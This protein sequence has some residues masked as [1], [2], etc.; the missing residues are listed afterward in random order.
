[1]ICPYCEFAVD[2]ED[3]KEKSITAG[4]LFECKYCDAELEYKPTKPNKLKNTFA[5]NHSLK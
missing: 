4:Q 3:L 2:T 5:H 1:M